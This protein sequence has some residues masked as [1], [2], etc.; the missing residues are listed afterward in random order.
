MVLWHCRNQLSLNA[1]KTKYIIIKPSNVKLDLTDH[2][3]FIG[4]IKLACTWIVQT[5]LRSL[6]ELLLMRRFH[7]NIM[8]QMKIVG[9]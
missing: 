3:I 1:K 5:F 4:G 7:G 9:L 8:F 6:L 2:N